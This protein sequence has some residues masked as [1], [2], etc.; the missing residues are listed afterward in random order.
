MLLLAVYAAIDI[1]YERLIKNRQASVMYRVD[2]DEKYTTVR[3]TYALAVLVY[4]LLFFCNC[5]YSL[6]VH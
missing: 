5:L 4:V 3:H 6:I 1:N 2:A